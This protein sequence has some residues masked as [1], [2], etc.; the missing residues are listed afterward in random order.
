MQD[1]YYYA[2]EKRAILLISGADKRTFLQSLISNDMMRVSENRSIFAAFLI[3]KVAPW[4]DFGC[5][6]ERLSI[7]NTIKKRRRNR[8]SKKH[9][10]KH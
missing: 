9:E 8:G 6:L 3:E 4:I 7:I 2:L 5:I 10:R 1:F